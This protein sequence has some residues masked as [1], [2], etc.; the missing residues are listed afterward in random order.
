MDVRNCR[1]CRKL[2]NYI[3]GPL[4]CPD[5]KEANEKKF[6][7]VK[8]YIRDNPHASI[9][10]VSEDM[11]ISVSQIQQWVREERLQFTEESGIALQCEKCGV[12]I[13]TGRFCENCK[14]KMANS[15]TKAFAEEKPQAPQKKK[16][17][18]NKM[19]FMK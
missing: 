18:G 7:D 10:Q 15:L 12:N 1:R 3:S 2:F 14:G 5:C 16:K 17:D 8:E 11:E 4:I 19:R 6:Y 13:Y 9:R